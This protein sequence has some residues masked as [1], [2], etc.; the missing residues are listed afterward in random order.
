[1][2]GGYD[3]IA[4]C[5]NILGSLSMNEFEYQGQGTYSA[6]VVLNPYSILSLVGV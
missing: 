2:D 4:D 3:E 1:M 6:S 5:R